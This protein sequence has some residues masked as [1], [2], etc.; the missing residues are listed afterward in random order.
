MEVTLRQMGNS[1]GVLIPKPILAQV[2]LEGAADLQVRNGVIEIRPLHRHPRQGWAEDA[3][4][5]AQEGEDGL[6]WPAF[7]NQDDDDLV[8]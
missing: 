7:A 4:R 5:L 2:G 6:V 1:R 3:E 8:W